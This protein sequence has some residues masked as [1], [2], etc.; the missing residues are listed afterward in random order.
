MTSFFLIINYLVIA[1]KFGRT[2][3]F[4]QIRPVVVRKTII[5]NIVAAQFTDTPF[6]MFYFSDPIIPITFLMRLISNSLFRRWKFLPNA[7]FPD[8]TNII[9]VYIVLK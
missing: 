2:L 3:I 4:V 1:Q 6:P 7:F 5:N 8:Q 9:I